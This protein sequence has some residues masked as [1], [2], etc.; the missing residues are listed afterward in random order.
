MKI[1]QIIFA[2]LCLNPLARGELLLV[3]QGEARCSIVVGESAKDQAAEAAADLQHYLERISGAT[4]PIV[5]AADQAKGIKILVGQAAAGAAA[6]GMGIELPTG[7]TH[8]FD[9]EGYVIAANNDVVILAGNETEPYEGT[10]YAVNA[11]LEDF[12]CRWYMPDAFGEVI[13][14]LENMTVK[15]GT[16]IARPEFRLR[17]LWYSGYAFAPENGQAMLNAWKRRNGMNFRHYWFNASLP[18]AKWLQAPVDNTTYRL[19][20]K[21]TYWDAHPEFYALNADGTRNDRFVCSSNPGAIDAAVDTIDQFFT[22]NPEVPSYG[23]APPDSPIL[24]HCERCKEAMNDGFGGEGFGEVSDP[25]FGFTIQV[26]DRIAPLHPDR[27]ILSMAYYNRCRPPQGVYGKRRNLLVVMA[28]IQQCRLHSYAI[29]SCR[30]FGDFKAMMHH[31]D[32]LAEGLIYYQYDPHDWSGFLRPAWRTRGIAED[33]RHLKREF[34]GWGFSIEGVCNWLTSGLNYYIYSKLAWDLELD[35]EAV[36]AEFFDTFFGPAAKPMGRYYAEVE[37]QLREADTHWTEF[38]SPTPDE[39]LTVFPRSFLDTCAGRLDEAAERG[40]RDPYRRRVAAFRAHFD[41][42]D[43]ANKACTAARACDYATMVKWDGEMAAA[44]DRVGDM[45]LLQDSLLFPPTY[46]GPKKGERAKELLSWTDGTR[47]RLLATVSPDA[48][49]RTDPDGEGVVHRWYLPETD[50]HGWQEMPL[51]KTWSGAGVG[52]LSGRPY[53]GTAWYRAGLDLD[54]EPEDEMSLM[55]PSFK[56]SGL[57]VWC[58][59]RFAGHC[60]TGKAVFDVSN[61]LQSG[62][63]EIVMRLDGNDGRIDAPF[64]FEPV[65]K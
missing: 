8:R 4:V 20:P 35:I 45:A 53:K 28:N 41:R 42:L 5:N 48:L 34:N 54:S 23:F 24:C 11:F 2:F 47:G 55:V 18:E 30:S 12:G 39:L 3:E 13:P 57:W 29:D 58:N 9:E 36:E 15:E 63:N 17:Y 1:L 61:S 59:G 10:Y 50:K 25:F 21:E 14:K 49:F 43:A 26:A 33:L 44:A 56:G 40:D 31:W 51:T 62:S 37:R 27:W 52:T 64:V 7:M 65:S 60:S 19:L 16:R 38:R 6:K 22:K 32:E 46:G